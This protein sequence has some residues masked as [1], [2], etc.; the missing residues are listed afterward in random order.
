MITR[1]DRY[2][3]RVLDL[4]N[5]LG[6]AEN[7]IVVFTSDNGTTHLKAEVDY[8]FFES[9]KPLRGLK[10]SLYEGGVRVPLIV[11]WPGKVKAGSTSDVVT[12]FE[13]WMPTLLDLIGEKSTAP[14]GI[15][16]ISIANTL[17]GKKQRPRKFLYREFSGYGGQQ[18]VWAGR[19][20]AVRQNILRKNNKTPLRIEL[21]DLKADISESNNV[22]AN[23]PKVVAR[24]KRIM[25]R[26]H[27]PSEFYPIKPLD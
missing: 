12:G 10:G 27:T 13:D 2:I 6:L 1:M 8:D 14:E 23:N 19:W 16:G 11:R 22:A 9:V 4:V 18:A 25:T 17:L 24:L 21:Y 7:T 26:E 20:K 15:D 3:G 5:E